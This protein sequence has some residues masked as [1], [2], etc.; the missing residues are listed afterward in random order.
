MN[1]SLAAPK[2]AVFSH[3]GKK[4]MRRA[5]LF[6]NF[7]DKLSQETLRRELARDISRLKLNGNDCKVG[8][9]L[10]IAKIYE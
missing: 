2:H 3:F 6:S 1:F 7:A 10:L 8:V 4:F 9:V 5:A